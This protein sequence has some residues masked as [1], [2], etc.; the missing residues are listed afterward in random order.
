MKVYFQI[1]TNNGNDNF[2]HLCIQNSPDL[3]ILVEANPMHY[4]DIVN[5]YSSIKNVNIVN[6][7]IYYENDQEVELYIPA[8]DGIY[9]QAA[10]QPSTSV[11]RTYAHGNFS[12]LP[13]QDW[14]EKKNMCTFKTQTITFDKI[15][16]DFNIKEIEYLQ[17]DTEGFDSEIIRMIDMEK[18]NIKQIRYEKWNFASEVFNEH[19]GNNEHIDPNKLGKNG[20]KLVKEKLEKYGYELKDIRDRYGDDI[21]ATKNKV[22]WLNIIIKIILMRKISVAIP[23]YNN[24]KFMKDT[25]EHIRN[26]ERISEIV[27]C[28]DRSSDY[29]DLVNLINS[30][31]NKKIILK[32]NDINLG[33]YHNKLH[34][35]AKCTNDWAILVDSDNIINT[36]YIDRLYEINE[37]N[38]RLVYAPSWA[39]TFPNE[40][41]VHLNYEKFKNTAID[42]PFFLNN[43]SDNTFQCLINTC[44]YFVPVQNYSICMSKVSY[45]RNIIDSLDSAVLFSDW[46][47][48]DGKVY[49]VPNMIYAHRCHPNSNYVRSSA[50]RHEPNVKRQIFAKLTQKINTLKR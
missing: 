35:L 13:M 36:D 34:T 11:V 47:Y 33:C 28:D 14:G 6:K 39:K 10:V 41:S 7:A 45:E 23:H 16:S 43:F 42:I 37:W 9:G 46:L 8:K 29:N 1:G 32:Q 20:M 22:Y 19:N 2:K 25:L 3:I 17:I 44:N 12:L 50:R 30:Y 5:N 38:D 26:D 48:D 49:I 40:P 21:L 27:I 31:N 24:T 18:I 4:N 15:C